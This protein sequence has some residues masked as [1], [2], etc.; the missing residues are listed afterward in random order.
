[1]SW[2]TF[3]IPFLVLVIPAREIPVGTVMP[4]M[5]SSRLNAAKD[6][7]QLARLA[8]NLDRTGS[9]I[10]ALRLHGISMF[11]TELDRLARSVA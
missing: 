3:A 7:H 5:L 10:K 8:F 11:E 9:E 4:V 2:I 6:K 1:M